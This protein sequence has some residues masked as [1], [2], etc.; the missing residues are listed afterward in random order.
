[1]KPLKPVIFFVGSTATGKSDLALALA[2]KHQS[3][4]VNGDSLQFYKELNIGTAKPGRETMSSYPHYLFDDVSA[5]EVMTAGKYRDKA[6]ELIEQHRASQP[7]YIVGGSGFYIQA[8][9]QGMY[10]VPRI[11]EEINKSLEDEFL[12]KPL[13][14]F[15]TELK[16][17]DPSYAQQISS[18]D[19]YRIF[20]A[21]NLIRYL[22]KPMSKIKEE[23]SSKP[24]I[25]PK[26]KIGLVLEKEKLRL[27]VKKRAQ[28]MIETGLI[29]EVKSLLEK[30]LESWPP[31][32]S[33]GYKETVSHIKGEITEDELLEKIV[34][35]TMQLAKKQ[36]TW[37]KRDKEIQ[38][39]DPENQK[40]EITDL[41]E[42]FH[43]KSC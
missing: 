33:V 37:F 11:P 38:W 24:L 21:I 39:F 40:Q 29:L 25:G 28:L 19:K 30:G 1:M 43:Q 12:E 8:V 6:I 16:D 3:L 2:K 14:V 4:L 7:V 42:D 20:R 13:S 27:K 5:P 34:T 35:S 18:E 23:F 9:D 32:R 17:K 36:K 22:D 10:D 26:L 31:L 15:F 41:V